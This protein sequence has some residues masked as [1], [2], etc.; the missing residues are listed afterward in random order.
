MKLGCLWKPDGLAQKTPASCKYI[1]QI[2]RARIGGR[3]DAG[4]A[5]FTTVDTEAV[6]QH[7]PASCSCS[8]CM[9]ATHSVRWCTFF[10]TS[11]SDLKISFFTLHKNFNH[12]RLIFKCLLNLIFWLHRLGNPFSTKTWKFSQ[13]EEDIC[14]WDKVILGLF[15]TWLCLLPLLHCVLGVTALTLLF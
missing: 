4:E 10:L 7:S 15:S 1:Y 13:V 5:A 8:V 14:H 6:K 9:W 3:D 2:Y 11:K 12:F